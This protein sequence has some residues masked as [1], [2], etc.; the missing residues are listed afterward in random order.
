MGVEKVTEKSRYR[1]FA[2]ITDLL[3]DMNETLS[4]T[5]LKIE[6][7]TEYTPAGLEAILSKYAF[8]CHI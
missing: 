2:K 7:N 8:F 5:G 4:Y 6:T 3:T 1:L